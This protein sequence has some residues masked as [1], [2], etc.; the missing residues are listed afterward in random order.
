MPL[1]AGFDIGIKNLAFC[2]IEKNDWKKYIKGEQDDPGIKM[3]RNINL[4]GEEPICS[5][6]IKSGVKKGQHCG[7]IACW[8]DSETY[9][10]GRHKTST[11]KSVKPKK[12]KNINMRELKRR[13]FCELDKIKLFNDVV[14]I[15]IESQ[16]RVNQQMKMFGASIESYFIIRQNIDNLSTKLRGIKSSP[17]KNKLRIY[18]GPLVST[19]HI[20]DPYKKRKYLAEKYTEYF[21]SRRQDILQELF[22]GKKRDDLADAFLH[23]ITAIG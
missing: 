14:Y 1:Y 18:N 10:C 4:L 9:F 8:V 21:L 3:W 15:A 19:V 7:K 13:A 2:I 23:C 5:T 6:A 17:A 16:P 20:K 22:C 11:C 12:V